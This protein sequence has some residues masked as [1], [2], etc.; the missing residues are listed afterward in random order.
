MSACRKGKAKGKKQQ[1]EVLQSEHALQELT[2]QFDHL[3]QYE[4]RKEEMR[5]LLFIRNCELTNEK[6]PR[7]EGKPKKK[8]L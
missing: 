3:E 2:A 5:Y 7:K 8:P 1:E 4:L 6:Y